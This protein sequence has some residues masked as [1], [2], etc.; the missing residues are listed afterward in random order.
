MSTKTK[1]SIADL[2][3]ER[4]RLALEREILI[5]KTEIQYYQGILDG[6]ISPENQE[7]E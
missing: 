3:Q 2:E 1:P 4:D 6:S 5:L 7:T